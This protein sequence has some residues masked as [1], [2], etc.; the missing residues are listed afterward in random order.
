MTKLD[1]LTTD[2]LNL[3]APTYEDAEAIFSTYASDPAVTTF[4][5]WPRHQTLDDTIAF[6][7]F[8]R[9]EWSRSSIGPYLLHDRNDN[10]LIGSTGIS[11]TASGDAMTGYVL[12]R[13]FWGCGLAT[14]AV[15]AMIEVARNLQLPSLFAICHPDHQA[16]RRVLDK[17]GFQ[18]DTT[19]SEPIVFPNIDGRPLVI[20][21]CYRQSIKREAS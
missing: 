21:T 11:C 13:P 12:A 2:R 17:T 16:S 3:R 7:D 10:T 20:P 8:A 15:K 14:E 19:W 5:G 9:S 1:V 6:I 18:Q 4:V